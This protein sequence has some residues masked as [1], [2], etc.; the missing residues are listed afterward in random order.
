MALCQLSLAKSVVQRMLYQAQ[1]AYFGA[2]L[3]LQSHRD[4]LAL[5]ELDRY[6]KIDQSGM[7]IDEESLKKPIAQL[8]HRFIE[9][10][11]SSMAACTGVSNCMSLLETHREGG[12]NC[13]KD[14]TIELDDFI[15]TRSEDLY[16]LVIVNPKKKVRYLKTK[17]LEA[18][19]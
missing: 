12:I 11:A 17:L 15:A 18:V 6:I 14:A 4:E 10:F 2:Q 7:L 13:Q 19:V 16:F 8:R 1:I 9:E 5:V 3:Y